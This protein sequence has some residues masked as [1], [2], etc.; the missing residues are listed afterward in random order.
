[1]GVVIRRLKPGDEMRAGEVAATFKAA[2]CPLPRA[3]RFLANPANYLIVAESAGEL[4]GFALAY[5][6]QRLDRAAAQLFVYE[7][8]VTPQHRHGGIGASLMAYVRNV[9]AE[10]SLIEAFVLT[11]QGNDAAMHLYRSTGGQ[12]EGA[13]SVL[14]VY[15]G[16][17]ASYHA[18]SSSPAT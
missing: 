11:D 16:H 15:P 8:G 9:V 17:A 10:E 1:V 2:Q 6:L 13:G 14:F 3:R 5:R 7:V 4:A 18:S 12:V